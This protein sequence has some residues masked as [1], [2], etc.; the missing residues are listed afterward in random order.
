MSFIFYNTF[1]PRVCKHIKLLV[2]EYIKLGHFYAIAQ[3][4]MNLFPRWEWDMEK[5]ATDREK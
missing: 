4:F 1:V 5:V 2:N 3:A